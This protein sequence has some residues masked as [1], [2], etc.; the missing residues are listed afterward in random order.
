MKQLAPQVELA[1]QIME[2][3][4]NAGILHHKLDNHTFDGKTLTIDGKSKTYFGNCSYL[5]LE[6]DERLKQAV[7]ESVQKFGIQ[8]SS[9]RTYARMPLYEEAEDLL[10]QIFGKPTIAAPSTTLAH[11]ATLPNLV[12]RN[13][14]VII[15]QQAHTS[16]YNVMAMFKSAGI[17]VERIRHNDMN[18]LESHIM[19][20]H[21]DYDRIWFLT[22]GVYSM[23]GDGAPID[24]MWQLLQKYDKLHLYVD[25]AHGMSCAGERGEGWALSQFPYFHERMVLIVSLSKGFGASGGAI[26]VPTEEMRRLIVNVGTSLVFTIQMPTATLA[27]IVAS[28][29]I[30]LSAEIT[31]RQDR[32]NQLMT[33]FNITAKAKNLPLIREAHTPI[34]YVGVGTPD[35]GAEITKRML[36]SGY[37][38]NPASYPSVPYK[39]TGVR[40]L[41]TTHL[42]EQDIF[43]MTTTLSH[44]LDEMEAK[45]TITRAEIRQAFEGREEKKQVH[46]QV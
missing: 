45:K 37:L 11:I 8:F 9:S 16:M 44:H 7:I 26:V 46:A 34:N 43:D 40:I 4:R 20:F 30:H 22:D 38:L 5:G 15:D 21:N 39:H 29:K 42:T 35:S 33:Y 14:V 27:A 32:L 13:D 41:I 1:N 17:R 19:A 23:F 24:D 18:A 2:Q 31:E 12:Q 36:D 6:T 28:A 10:T 3:G 25:D